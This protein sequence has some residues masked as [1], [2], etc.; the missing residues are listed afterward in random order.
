[1]HSVKIYNHATAHHPEA[2]WRHLLSFV[3]IT[4]SNLFKRFCNERHL[5]VGNG[6]NKK[7]TETFMNHTNATL[8]FYF[9]TMHA[10]CKK[11]CL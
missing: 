8:Y 11:T 6:F 4:S 7:E 10:Y 1:M 5:N 2:L 9:Y 3:S